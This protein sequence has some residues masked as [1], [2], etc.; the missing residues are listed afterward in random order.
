MP[1]P[2]FFLIFISQINQEMTREDTLVQMIQS[3]K[4]QLSVMAATNRKQN[5]TIVSQAQTIE[6]LRSTIVDLNAS[7][8]WLKRKVFGKMSEK[9]KPIKGDPMLPFTD[10]DREQVEA[11]IEEARNRAAAQITVPKVQIAGKNIPP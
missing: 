7:L 11:E 1:I 8:A 4:E 2:I 3:L 6:E 10:G 5:E 9:C